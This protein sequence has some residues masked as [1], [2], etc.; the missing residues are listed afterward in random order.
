MLVP[1]VE[2]RSRLL[3]PYRL[4]VVSL[5]EIG[6]PGGR[7]QALRIPHD[8]ELPGNEALLRKEG[9]RLVIE[10]VRRPSLLELAASAD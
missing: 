2:V 4:M 10:P 9:D 5:E 8:L 6:A 7:N 3:D 1:E